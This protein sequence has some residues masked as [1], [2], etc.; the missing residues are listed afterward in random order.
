MTGASDDLRAWLAGQVR[1]LVVGPAAD[2]QRAT[3][4]DGPGERWFEAGSEIH[5]VHADSAMFVGGLRA[6]LLQALH[7][8]AM[9]GVADHS[10]YRHDPWGRLQRTAYFL[11]ATTF[12]TAEQ[13]E[14]AV[15]RVRAVHERVTGVAPDGR[16]YAANDPH[17]LRW[18]HLAEIDS[19][20]AAH[21]RYGAEPLTPVEADRYVAQT[22]VI[23]RALGVPAPPESVQALR[24]QLRAFR[25]ELQGTSQARDVARY[26]L[27]QPPLSLPGRVAYGVL[28]SAAVALLPP[29]ARRPLRLPWLP[30]TEAVAVRPAGEAFT[31]TLRWALQAPDA[32]PG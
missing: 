20:L 26:L 23:A 9:A 22:A 31:R 16:P 21:Q 18:V 27:W 3:I 32:A 28:A 7:P 1:E 17:L 2:E 15:A 10:D 19:F 11:A 4:L 14:A 8:L 13:A 29:W 6:L 24:D 25:R 30:V 5:R 12:G